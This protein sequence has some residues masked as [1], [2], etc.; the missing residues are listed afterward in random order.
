MKK[1]ALY[2]NSKTIKPDINDNI[3]ISLLAKKEKYIDINLKCRNIYN[4]K[5]YCEECVSRAM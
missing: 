3:S 4:Y 5:T 1:T 2:S